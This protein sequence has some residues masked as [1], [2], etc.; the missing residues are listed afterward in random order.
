LNKRPL[1]DDSVILKPDELRNL[2]VELEFESC[3][4]WFIPPELLRLHAF[5]WSELERLGEDPGPPLKDPA[6]F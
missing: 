4:T 2:L 5:T 3:M 6:S 1:D